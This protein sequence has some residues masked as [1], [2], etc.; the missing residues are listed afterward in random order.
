MQPPLAFNHNTYNLF[1]ITNL[2]R[3]V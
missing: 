2:L 3:H 1:D